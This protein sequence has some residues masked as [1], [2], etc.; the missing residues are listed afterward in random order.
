MSV[1]KGFEEVLRIIGDVDRDIPVSRLSDLSDVDKDQ[2]A[3]FARVWE[4]LPRDRKR[5][6]IRLL[7]E[8]SYAHVEL[9]FDEL[10]RLSLADRDAQVRQAAIDNLWECED[11]SL[12]TPFLK[13]LTADPEASVRR[14]AATALGHYVLLGEVEQ[15]Q[16]ESL[17]NVEEALLAATSTDAAD[18]V[19]Q[20]ALESL[21][22]SSRPEVPGLIVRAF[23]SG[24][25]PAVIS[26]LIAIGRT[27]NDEWQPQV[28]AHLNDPAPELRLAAVRAAGELELIE[29]APELVELLEDASDDVRSAAIWSLGQA[30]GDIAKE[31]LAELLET[32][33]DAEE[34]QLVQDALDN[35]AFVDGTRDLLMFDFDEPE[36]D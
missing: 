8:E 28:K 9:N 20:A 29:T 30:G 15:L 1:T 35:L 12:V 34:T 5:K 36:A 4:G 22:F 10:N 19:R 31:A 21:G 27:A 3:R 13:A 18:E 2:L 7:G 32:S 23:E 24:S 6:L 16:P 25:E 11:P 14:S 26:S 17:H 33:E